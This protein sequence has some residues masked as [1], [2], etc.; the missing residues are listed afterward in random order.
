[1]KREVTR[2]WQAQQPVVDAAQRELQVRRST[3]CNWVGGAL[4][5][6]GKRSC[7][8]CVHLSVRASPAQLTPPVRQLQEKLESDPYLRSRVGAVRVE[9]GRKALYR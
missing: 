7:V 5:L 1:M 9:A 4:L 3:A 2:L 6:G 8:L